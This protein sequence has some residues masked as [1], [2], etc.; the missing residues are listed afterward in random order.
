MVSSIIFLFIE[1]DSAN[2]PI[3]ARKIINIG[4]PNFNLFEEGSSLDEESGIT[5]NLGSP[6]FNNLQ[7]NCV[8]YIGGPT[9]QI[10]FYQDTMRANI[11]AYRGILKPNDTYSVLMG[12]KTNNKD[13]LLLATSVLI[14][15]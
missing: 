1:T 8:Y 10:K 15:H 5:E 3:L 13:M 7:V 9:N 2:N 14:K 6:F 11:D 12:H 4:G